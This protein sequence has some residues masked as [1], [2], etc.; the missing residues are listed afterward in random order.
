MAQAALEVR[1]VEPQRRRGAQQ[2][3]GLPVAAP[4]A[5]PEV[6]GSGVLVGPRP[7][8]ER[9]AERDARAAAG[10]LVDRRDLGAV[11]R[12]ERRLVGLDLL[13]VDARDRGEVG[14]ARLEHLAVE[15]DLA[16]RVVEDLRQP[17]ALPLL[18]RRGRHGREL[19]QPVRK[20]QV[21]DPHCSLEHPVGEQRHQ[22]RIRVGPHAGAGYDTLEPAGGPNRSNSHYH[23]RAACRGWRR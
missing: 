4:D 13:L 6:D 9:V 20:T 3:D 16:P 8:V 7:A 19:A 5:L 23:G 15:R 2:H 12:V 11:G 18:A 21:R 1:A 17:L 14:A 22:V 10:L